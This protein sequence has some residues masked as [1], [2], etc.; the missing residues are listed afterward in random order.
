MRQAGRRRGVDPFQI[1]RRVSEMPR[2][3]EEAGHRRERCPEQTPMMIVSQVLNAY[4]R[5]RLRSARYREAVYHQALRRELRVSKMG[6]VVL[7]NLGPAMAQNPAYHSE[8]KNLLPDDN[9]QKHFWESDLGYLW[10]CARSNDTY[11]RFAIEEIRKHKIRSLLDVGCGWGRFCCEVEKLQLGVRIKGIDISRNIINEARARNIRTEVQF[12]WLD[13][14]QE[15][16][17]FDMITL[18][19]SADYISP[20]VF[21]DLLFHLI[22]LTNKELIIVNSLRGLMFETVLELEEAKEVKRYDDGFVQPLGFLA[23]QWQ[24]TLSYAFEIK[25]CGIDSQMAV[26]SKRT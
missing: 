1:G 24:E 12:E 7:R 14:R 5:F 22:R 4:V 11:F 17:R 15:N 20:E 3:L 25:K 18:I 21:T 19:G 2:L 16:G 23:K 26:I 10:Y 9:Y 13:A 8:F 6:I